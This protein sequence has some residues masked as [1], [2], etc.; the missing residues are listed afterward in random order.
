MTNPQLLD[1]I[2]QQL[3]QG[4]NKGN[5]KASLFQNGWRN[6]DIEEA[7]TLITTQDQSGLPNV[8]PPGGINKKAL[9]A[10][11][12]IGVLVIGGGI[13]GYSVFI[14]RDVTVI[15]PSLVS[16]NP[17]LTETPVSTSPLATTQKEAVSTSV[18]TPTPTPALTQ[19]TKQCPPFFKVIS[20]LDY[21]EKIVFAI[22]KEGTEIIPDWRAG[23]QRIIDYVNNTLSKNTR[24]RYRI[25]K[26]I[27]YNTSDYQKLD[28]QR[29]N[30]IDNGNGTNSGTTIFEYIYPQSG[31]PD[32][33]ANSVFPNT[34]TER[35]LDGKKFK[36][37]WIVEYE[38]ISVLREKQTIEAEKR[39]PGTYDFQMGVVL[40]ELGHSL[41]LG[42]PERY[43]FE[44]SDL[45]GELP[46]LGT[47]SLDRL[48]PGDPM[49]HR[50]SSIAW[51]FSDLDAFIINNN[52]SHQYDLFEIGKFEPSHTIV[53]V[54]DKANK[55]VT[56]AT[57]KVYGVKRNCVGCSDNP[58]QPLQQALRTD[59]KGLVEIDSLSP[60][61]NHPKY[62]YGWVA[63]II[64]VSK[65]GMR[66]GT[67]A[68]FVDAQT[69]CLI[70]ATETHY[71]DVKL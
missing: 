11:A 16:L 57:V 38:A 41:G 14:N 52:A 30:Y 7:F 27:V 36:G 28:Q 42:F 31:I 68:T 4:I 19:A 46:N 8:T 6:A 53:R 47:Y 35:I 50:Q 48:Q 39:T 25:E 63:K 22:N 67:F 60:I 23:A 45:T 37:V 13:M 54:T 51:S 33:V 71:I 5:I 32:I 24:K 70:N 26:F 9:L 12:I 1:Y 55:P 29:E 61:P 2:R 43:T 3:Q 49:T 10:V 20:D 15:P 44:F 58:G 66:A 64:K 21:V 56:N 69:A 17:P 18:S 34:A 59:E 65:D 40:H 62:N